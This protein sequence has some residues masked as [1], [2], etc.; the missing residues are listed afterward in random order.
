MGVGGT[1]TTNGRGRVRTVKG[2][3]QRRGRS[4]SRWSAGGAEPCRREERRND[5]KGRTK[6]YEGDTTMNTLEQRGAGA[7]PREVSGS[8]LAER[9]RASCGSGCPGG[10]GWNAGWGAKN[11]PSTGQQG[12]PRAWGTGAVSVEAQEEA[13]SGQP[14]PPGTPGGAIGPR[15]A[16]G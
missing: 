15:A 6:T 4:C 1:N 3:K 13:V 12:A 8:F 7:R 10:G 2:R 5:E 14:W 9:R 11:R 16:G